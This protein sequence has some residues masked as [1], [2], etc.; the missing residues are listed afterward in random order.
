MDRYSFF[1]T[2]TTKGV[3]KDNY[4]LQ[5]AD[6]LEKMEANIAANLVKQYYRQYVLGEEY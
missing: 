4:I 2:L 1:N 6:M 3:F 5:F